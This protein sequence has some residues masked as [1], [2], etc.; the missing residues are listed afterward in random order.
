MT[1]GA[2]DGARVSS[3]PIGDLALRP[4]PELEPRTSWT[5]VR[6]A[7]GVELGVWEMA[8]G[9]AD[10]VEQE[11]VFV[12]V[13]GRATIAVVGQQ[14]VDIGVG[15]LVQMRAGTSTRWTVH[16]TLRKFYVT[17]PA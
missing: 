10:D 6:T 9:Q 3:R 13:A 14:P 16:E 12:V 1:A 4:A 11:E 8:P 7:P 17:L 2:A 15:D 5:Q